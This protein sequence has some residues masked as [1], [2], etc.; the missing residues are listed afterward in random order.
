MR[1]PFLLTIGSF[2]AV[3]FLAP[4]SALGQ[5]CSECRLIRR[6]NVFADRPEP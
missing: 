5:F 2:L 1:R 6:L 3:V 4:P